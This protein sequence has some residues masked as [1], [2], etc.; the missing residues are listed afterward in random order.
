[1]CGMIILPGGSDSDTLS[2]L[3]SSGLG[4]D[5][6]EVCET[7]VDECPDRGST[8][9]ELGAIRPDT[10]RRYGDRPA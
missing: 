10:A 8:L 6:S 4:V 3:A 5:R 1:M 7:L 2:P 9:R